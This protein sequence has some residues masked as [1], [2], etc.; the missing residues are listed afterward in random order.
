VVKLS[1]IVKDYQESGALNAL[2]SIHAAI[3]EHTFLTKGGDLAIF[4]AVRGADYEC[5][6]G[7]QCDQIARRFEAALRV[8]DEN[9]RVYQYVDK[10]DNAPIPHRLY[11]NPVVQ[12]AIKSRIAYL[13]SKSDS[14][15]SL[16]TYFVVVYEG[17]SHKGN[18]HGRLAQFL[19]KPLTGLREILS[20]ANT[21]TVL[22]DELNRACEILA[23][24][25]MGFVIQLPDGVSAEVLDK[26]RAFRFLRRLL[27]YAPS[28]ADAVRLKYDR[29]VDFQA[30]SSALECHRD[31]LRL[32]DFYVSVL[33]LKGPPAQTYANMVRDLQEIPCKSVLAIEW[34]REN[35]AK[36]RRM[37]QSK[38]RHFHNMKT[39]L[40]NYLP[41]SK[42]G[43]G[44]KDLLID[45]SAVALVRELGTCLE[46]L[47]VNGRYFGQFSLTV[48][49]Y[50]QDRAS[51]R[52]AV[53]ECLK[54]FGAHDAHL[55]EESYNL[56]NA[57]L[58][59]LPGNHAY[60]LRRLWL[61]DTNYADLSFLF[62]IRNG[63]PT[64]D[65]LNAE[66]L[67]VLET[68]HR[69]PYY[70]NLHYQ[71]T[72]H[73]LLLGAPG[74][75]KSFC[76]NFLV[77]NAQKYAPQTY[78]FDLGGS[79]ESLTRLFQGAYLAIGVE[80][81][82]FTINPFS[83]APTKEN[84][85][86]LFSFLKV[87]MESSTFAMSSED[88][89]DLYNQIE[90]LYVIEPDQRRL[91][92]LSNMLNRRLRAP[93]QKWV[94]GGQYEAWFDN[95]ADNLTFATFQTFDFEGMDKVPQVLEPL[96]FY[97]LHRANAVIYDPAHTATFKMFVIDE[98]WRFLRHPTIRLYILE[99]LKTWRKKNAAMILA[100]QSSDDLLRSEMLSVVVE[101]C[102]TK[103]FLA[104]PDIDRK[105]YR[106]IFHLNETESEIVARL[107]PKQQILV[108]RPDLAKVV[109]LTVDPKSYWLYTSSPYD[110]ER[111]RE[112]FEQHGFE[113]GLE[114]LAQS[115]LTRSNAL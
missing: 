41:T 25:V 113:D 56:L 82:P 37:I 11:D 111:R 20:T 106:E 29:F 46:E 50:D 103:M 59:V 80:Q 110:R 67:A 36:M 75:G 102:A 68:N 55:I 76:V 54:I 3:D 62:T 92:T 105:L 81:R 48:I 107:V 26:Q 97:I 84:L 13:E 53:A 109:N 91:L 78:I 27:N 8:F 98:A 61:L 22:E 35:N 10:R 19:R 64:N 31:Q 65:H 70:L 101:S 47:E 2:V 43:S 33:T 104:N 7:S 96:L 42:D 71:D 49:L 90:N 85:R 72:A 57:W 44:P 94:Q 32:D 4:L 23:N 108:K 93:L 5:L 39:S 24:K 18:L 34:K 28:K 15:Y 9:F 38:R 112:A 16:E 114:I 66:Y 30:A 74:S 115:G 63:E 79:Y 12:E 88:E 87:L 95:V 14:L 83:L 21:I 17:W 1:R 89:R 99:A 40:A 52:R 100:T 6:D 77:T 51:L 58:A 69:T 45:D 60:N 73:T 86:F